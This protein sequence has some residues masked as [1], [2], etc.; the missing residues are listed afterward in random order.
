MSEKFKNETGSENEA[1]ERLPWHRP[2]V[3]T[4]DVIR[5]TEGG[6]ANPHPG[7]DDTWYVS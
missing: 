4:F 5:A 2:S 7:G 1:C 3:K 6:I